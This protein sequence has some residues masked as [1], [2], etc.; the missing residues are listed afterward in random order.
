MDDE[1]SGRVGWIV[2]RRPEAQTA[3]ATAAARAAASSG[4]ATSGRTT[5]RAGRARRRRRPRRASARR[6]RAKLG[7]VAARRR[8]RG[9]RGRRGPPAQSRSG[10]RWRRPTRR[11]RRAP[12]TRRRRCRRTRRR[13]AGAAA[14]A[15]AAS[16]ARRASR[17]ARR[18]S[19]RAARRRPRRARRARPSRAPPRRA[20]LVVA[21][22]LLEAVVPRHFCAERLLHA[23][24]R[25]LHLL[26]VRLERAVL[27]RLALAA[28]EERAHVEEELLV[29]RRV[30]DGVEARHAA[31]V[32]VLANFRCCAN[33]WVTT[34]R[35]GV[36]LL[37][38]FFVRVDA[39][40]HPY[41]GHR[42]P[43]PPRRLAREHAGGAAAGALGVG[44]PAPS[45]DALRA[46][47]PAARAGHRGERGGARWERRAVLGEVA[48][49]GRGG[50]GAR[51]R[52][53]RRWHHAPR[54]DARAQ[55]GGD[56]RP[57]G[58][59]AR[60]P[61]HVARARLQGPGV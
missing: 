26:A 13:R 42:R 44:A 17:R 29:L 31:A 60:R 19:P 33:L 59:R 14:R 36:Q 8:R 12:R 56:G 5:Q 41:G 10:R 50:D 51:L 6:R 25:G 40:P 22:E 3:A 9:V 30:G 28:L 1:R 32:A 57:R 39:P 55:A 54:A 52:D 16:A 58:G 43:P 15:R 45:V 53:G 48:E 2:E 24:E 18:G 11:A 49:R 35:I 47:P 46:L 34:L 21:V 7:G 37:P 38:G 27:R 20:Q 4:R 23:P 61:R